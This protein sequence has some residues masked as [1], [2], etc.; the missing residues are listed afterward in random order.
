M[1]LTFLKNGGVGCLTLC[2]T[3]MGSGFNSDKYSLLFCNGGI[4]Y[5]RKSY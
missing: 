4:Y 1:V 2:A 3:V 5:R